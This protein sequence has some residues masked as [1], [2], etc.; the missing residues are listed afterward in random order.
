M[1][2]WVIL[3][4]QTNHS[5]LGFVRCV[6]FLFNIEEFEYFIQRLSFNHFCLIVWSVC[7]LKSIYMYLWCA[8]T[9]I[10]YR[11]AN[12]TIQ[13][14]ST[15]GAKKPKKNLRQKPIWKDMGGKVNLHVVFS[16]WEFV[17]TLSER[18][19]RNS[20]PYTRSSG[21]IWT[22]CSSASARIDT[23]YKKIPQ[24]PSWNN[25]RKREKCKRWVQA[26]FFFALANRINHEI[27]IRN[28]L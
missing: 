23:F 25:R 18:L 24:T 7:S 1:E 26:F 5:F 14:P 4:S 27:S 11:H 9:K 3:R 20:A 13:K 16:A 8:C 2:F 19:L 28:A 10:P 21:W 6:S 22:Q 17:Y 12:S 15:F